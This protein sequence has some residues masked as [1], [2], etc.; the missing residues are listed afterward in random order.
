MGRFKKSFSFFLG[1]NDMLISVYILF[2]LK[3]EKEKSVNECMNQYLNVTC[4][5]LAFLNSKNIVE[6]NITNERY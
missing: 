1:K 6:L 2:K 5:D 4:I 3:K